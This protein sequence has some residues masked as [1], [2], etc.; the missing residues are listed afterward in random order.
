MAT[1]K[2]SNKIEWDCIYNKVE[3]KLIYKNPK[4]NDV[5]NEKKIEKIED[6]DDYYLI[7]WYE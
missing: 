7:K 2:K 6:K 5:V 3:M 1:R 4:E